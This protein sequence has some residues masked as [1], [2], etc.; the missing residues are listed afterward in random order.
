MLDRLFHARAKL[1]IIE[2][3]RKV[4]GDVTRLAAAIDR[5]GKVEAP[6]GGR[7]SRRERFAA[8]AERR[9]RERTPA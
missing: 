7:L 5:V 3:R 1:G 6:R 2:R 8:A 9:K 4:D